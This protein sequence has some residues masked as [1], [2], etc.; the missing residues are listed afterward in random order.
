MT[1]ARTSMGATTTITTYENEVINVRFRYEDGAADA[2]GV[3]KARLSS[4]YRVNI[5]LR[6]V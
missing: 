2:E 1:L 5:K 4:H 3:V 6:R